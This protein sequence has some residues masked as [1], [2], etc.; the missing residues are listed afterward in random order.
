MDELAKPAIEV[1]ER[2]QVRF[3]PGRWKRV[4]L[5]WMDR[6]RPWCVSRQLWWGH[7]L[8]V[9]YCDA[10]EETYV[11]EVAPERCGACGGGL[12]Q[13]EDV[14]D[15]WFSSGLWPFGVL[16]WPVET[17][18]LRAFY[19]TDVLVT[20]RDIIFLW[21]ARMVMM[22]LSRVHRRGSLRGRLH[23]LRDPSSRRA[24]DVEEPRHRHRSAGRDPGAWSRW[25]SLRA[26]GHVLG[27]GCALLRRSDPAGRGPGEQA[28][29]R[30]ATDPPQRLNG[31]PR[32]GGGWRG[33]ARP[34]P[35]AGRGP[36]DPLPASG[37]DRG[38]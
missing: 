19:P 3:V 34:A 1:V 21:V 5:D 17:P 29:E 25:R 38:R 23:H 10:C 22:E 28:L 32:G 2:D 13:D 16:G 7:R 20:A 36:L 8:P 37:G 12:R 15:T 27:P 26:A 11:A 6:L 35:R 18:E 4:Y 14:L 24:A 9:W 30:I 31:G 33:R